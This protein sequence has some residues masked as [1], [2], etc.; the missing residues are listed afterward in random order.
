MGVVLRNDSLLMP[1]IRHRGLKCTLI[2][3]KDSEASKLCLIL[4]VGELTTNV[5][6]VKHFQRIKG[7]KSY[8]YQVAGEY[9]RDCC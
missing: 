2:I 7:D 6:C 9:S 5:S 3:T 1:F 4:R 8:V